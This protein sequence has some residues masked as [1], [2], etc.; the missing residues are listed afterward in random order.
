MLDALGLLVNQYKFLS[1][2]AF[3]GSGHVAKFVLI[4]QY[5]CIGSLPKS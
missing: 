4:H 2:R 3:H 5:K 1:K